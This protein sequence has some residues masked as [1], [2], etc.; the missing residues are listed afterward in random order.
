[1]TAVFVITARVSSSVTSFSVETTSRCSTVTLFP[2]LIHRLQCL[3]VTS[4]AARYKL[5]VVYTWSD[6]TSHPRVDTVQLSNKSQVK[7]W[8]R[9]T[10]DPKW[11][12]NTIGLSSR[13]WMKWKM[14]AILQCERNSSKS[15][16]YCKECNSRN[17]LYH[18]RNSSRCNLMTLF[19]CGKLHFIFSKI[20]G[21]FTAVNNIYV[22]IY[23]LWRIKALLGNNLINTFP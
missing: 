18:E 17:K 11:Y 5:R 19:L 13:Q 9:N 12:G 21:F 20:T 1:L 8:P 23:T 2:L 10:Q 14:S 22:F 4:A 15:N 7:M 16:L 3:P 6:V